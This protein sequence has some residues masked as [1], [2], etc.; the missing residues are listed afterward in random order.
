MFIYEFQCR[1]PTEQN[2]E[3]YRENKKEYH[4]LLQV[5]KQNYYHGLLNNTENYSKTGWQIINT[6]TGRKIKVSKNPEN[7]T[8]DQL[9]H[10]FVNNMNDMIGNSPMSHNAIKF[11]NESL[12]LKDSMFLRPIIPDDI[13]ILAHKLKNK[14]TEDLKGINAFIIKKCIAYLLDPLTDIINTC[15]TEGHFPKE[16][17]IAKVLP[18]HKK[19]ENSDPKNFRQISILP[20]FSKLLEMVIYEQLTVYLESNNILCTQQFGF[21]KNLSTSDAIHTLTNYIKEAFEN[22]D[23][24][25]G[26]FTDLTSAFDCVN[27]QILISKLY[28]YGVREYKSGDY[29]FIPRK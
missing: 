21:R 29:S 9:N 15:I 28:F 2:K 25:I 12:N 13:R 3:I 1:N 23:K 8:V 11:M 26:V 20:T 10:F 22:R 14:K 27:H 24:Y 16:M 17:K 6:E 18:V 19:G 4:N 5:A 7:L